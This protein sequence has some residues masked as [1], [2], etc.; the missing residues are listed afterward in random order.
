[1]DG[2]RRPA[3]RAEERTLVLVCPR[4]LLQARRGEAAKGQRPRKAEAAEE[5]EDGGPVPVNQWRTPKGGDGSAKRSTR[6]DSDGAAALVKRKPRG[7]H[8]H[9][10][11]NR[12][13]FAQSDDNAHAHERGCGVRGAARCD[14]REG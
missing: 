14:H 13:A 7:D 4:V 9:Q 12:D 6:E 2:R 11:G 5:V 1:M 8:G 10:G 3:T